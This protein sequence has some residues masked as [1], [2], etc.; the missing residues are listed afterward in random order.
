[1]ILLVTPS[2]RGKDCAQVLQGATGHPTHVANTLQTAISS[3]RAEEYAAVVIDQFLLETE[4]DECDL[5][6]RHL[7]SAVPVYVN[8]GIS[9]AERIARE[10][11]SALSRRQREEQAVR[12]SAEQ[13]I[14]SE[15][16][17]SVTAMLLSCDLALST[18]GMSVAAAEKMQAARNQAAHIRSLLQ[19]SQEKR[20]IA[21]QE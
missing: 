14:W 16:N 11:R 17:E 9:G 2:E 3:L 10:V 20:Q 18:R 8:C 12:R 21:I 4:P 5:V 1:M 15:L 6:L 19:V 13:A 7:A